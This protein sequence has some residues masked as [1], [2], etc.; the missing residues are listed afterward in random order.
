MEDYNQHKEMLSLYLSQGGGVLST[1][2]VEV[3]GYPFGSV[4]P[5]CLDYDFSPVILIS[6]LA[7]HT[8]NIKSNENVCLTIIQDSDQT[9]KQNKGRL[10]FLGRAQKVENPEFIKLR[11]LNYFPSAA[12]YFETHSFDFY[13]IIPTRIRFI[14]GFG[15]IYWIEKEDFSFNNIIPA[16]EELAA[17]NHMNEDHVQNLKAYAKSFL[18]IENS[19]ELV[20]KLSGIDQFGCD[21]LI[22]SRKYR[23]DFQDILEKTMSEASEVR[24]FFVEMAKMSK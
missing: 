24:S 11:Y 5:Y 19:E 3:E 10:S 4:T 7:Q 14:G 13:K 21:L 6:D 12:A 1:H 2:S 18:N 16:D 9:N 8:K 20:I 22:D 17:V 15:K 23:L